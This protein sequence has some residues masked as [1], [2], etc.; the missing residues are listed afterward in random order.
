M[1]KKKQAIYEHIEKIKKR[2]ICE[3]NKRYE[4]KKQQK[5]NFEKT[6]ENIEDKQ[7]QIKQRIE[8][9]KTTTLETTNIM[10]QIKK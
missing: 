5:I 1:T 6:H 8:Q 9:K 3:T 2:R 10:E 4:K 7:H